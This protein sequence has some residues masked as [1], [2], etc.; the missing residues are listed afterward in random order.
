MSGPTGGR[1]VG[2]LGLGAMG[3]AMAGRLIAAQGLVVGYDPDTEAVTRLVAR[4]GQAAATP[5]ACSDGCFVLIVMVRDAAQA[6]EALFGSSGAVRALAGGSTVWLAST[7]PP[8]YAAELEG[9]LRERGIHCLDGPVSGGVAG[10]EAG[11]LTVICAG[12]VQARTAVEP[13]LPAL[14]Q[15]VFTVGEQAGAASS[16]KMINQML[17]A[18]HVA[19][20][21]EALTLAMSAGLEPSLLYRIVCASAGNSRM[22]EARAPRMFGSDIATGP[23]LAIFRKDLGIALDEA[24]RLGC[25]MPI[26]GKAARL[27]DF[28]AEHEG[29]DCPDTVLIRAYAKLAALPPEEWV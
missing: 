15:T 4:G 1:R 25:P 13:L 3:S 9:R 21:A 18:T 29:A 7:V 22:F 17:T 26:S 10:A 24:R 2:V 19:L 5:A 6:D 14:A 27:F 12:S 16:A 11:T 20:T 23:A 28:A 8:A